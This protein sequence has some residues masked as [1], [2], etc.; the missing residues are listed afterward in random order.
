[1]EKHRA[2]PPGCMSVGE[3]AKKMG[4]TVRTLQHYHRE[5]LL[6]PAEGGRRLY[7][8]RDVIR[9]HQI[10]SL[11]RLGFSL[12]DI[13]NR[14][15]SLDD[16]SEVAEIL[17]EQAAA[18]REKIRELSDALARI[19]ALRAEALEMQAVDFK[20]YAD[21][22]VNLEMK[23][24][25]Y[26]LI[27]HFDSETLDHIRLRFDRESGQAFLEKFLAMQ[28]EAI[29]LG[30]DGVP[31]AGREGQDFAKAYCARQTPLSNRRWAPIFPILG[32]TPFRRRRYD[33]C[34]TGEEPAKKLWKKRGP[35][36]RRPGRGP[37][38]GLC[39]AGRERR[40][41]NHGAGVHRG[42]AEV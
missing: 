12:G 11:K 4:V 29:R 33:T 13:K 18:V 19:E 2:I 30:A 25:F 24:D 26:W 22:L 42:I 5:G 31:P 17:A 40:G 20:K 14:L 21:I 32:R 10:L 39:P 36:G 34:G 41:E 16:P 7:T 6:P 38:G 27:K 3:I 1:M 15:I 9:L 8:D 35:A 23:N 37:G 28:N